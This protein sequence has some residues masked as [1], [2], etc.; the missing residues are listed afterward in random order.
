MKKLFEGKYRSVWEYLLYL[1]PKVTFWLIN[2]IAA[3]VAAIIIAVL[4]WIQRR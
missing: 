1:G 2:F 3:T 4:I